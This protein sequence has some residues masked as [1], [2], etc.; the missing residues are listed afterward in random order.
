MKRFTPVVDRNSKPL[1]DLVQ[2]PNEKGTT[3]LFCV[4]LTGCA[5][6]LIG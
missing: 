6:Q 3:R 1:K 2:E 4:Y 5:L